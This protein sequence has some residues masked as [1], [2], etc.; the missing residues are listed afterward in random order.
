MNSFKL[1]QLANPDRYREFFC[2]HFYLFFVPWP[3]Y[4]TQK[5]L[6]QGTKLRIPARPAGGSLQSKKL[7]EFNKA[8]ITICEA[9]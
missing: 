1:F 7:N 3:N 2:T 5:S 8:K 9:V 4:A 6:Q